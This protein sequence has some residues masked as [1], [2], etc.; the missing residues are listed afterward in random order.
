M[1]E[2]ANCG[3]EFAPP[4]QKGPVPLYCSQSCRQRAFEKR[5]GDFN[6]EFVALAR[7]HPETFLHYIKIWA[8]LRPNQRSDQKWVDLVA[9]CRE[10]SHRV[11]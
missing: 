1:R 5:H 8:K 2:C 11:A 4:H 10:D 6:A 7:Q 3:R 9:C